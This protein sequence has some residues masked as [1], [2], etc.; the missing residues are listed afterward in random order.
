[1]PMHYQESGMNKEF[2]NK[3]PGQDIKLYPEEFFFVCMK[4][5][6]KTVKRIWTDFSVK[7]YF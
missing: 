1:M 6:L 2:R 5:Y 3:R 7:I 4:F